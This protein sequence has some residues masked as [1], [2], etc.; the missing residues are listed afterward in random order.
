MRRLVTRGSAVLLVV[1]AV[2]AVGLPRAFSDPSDLTGVWSLDGKNG[3]GHYTG[4]VTLAKVGVAWVAELTLDYDSGTHGT[5][6]V[7]ATFDGTVLSGTRMRTTGITGALTG[8]KR[9]PY[10][11]KYTLSADGLTLDGTYA[12]SF[13]ERFT[14]KAAPVTGSATI[15]VDADR[16]GALTDK[17]RAAATA[18]KTALLTLVPG[19][20]GTVLSPIQVEVK[21]GT[22]TIE[23]APAGAL[24]ITEGSNAVGELALGTHSL[25][26]EAVTEG[27]VEVR[28]V[29]GGTVV[30]RAKITVEKEKLYLILG[31]YFSTEITYQEGD[32]TK[33]K[34]HILPPLQQA[35]YTVIEDGKGYDQSVID[36]RL[37]DPRLSKKVIVDWCTTDDDFNHYWDRQTVKAYFWESHGF[38]EPYPGC[39]D[40]ELKV[41]ESRQWTAAPGDPSNTGSRHFV[42]DWKAKLDKNGYATLDF[43]VNHACTTGGIGDYSSDPWEYTDADTLTR[44][45]A[46]LGDPLPTFDKLSYT[47]HAS[48]KGS[49]G[50]QQNYDGSAYFGVYDVTWA[51]LVAAIKP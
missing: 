4:S 7:D 13:T 24:K 8:A 10:P 17:D 49:F 51:S 6:R 3:T 41:L 20:P 32:L 21:T 37:T 22:A 11:A 30:D 43:G 2:S 28:V 44:A 9:T 5:A 50:F 26:A 31:A 29:S 18:G 47:T 1:L 40:A 27:D 39:P 15:L 23:L 46:V 34:S 45:K 14:R 42:R 48:L 38:M 19:A 25:M 12:T 16:D 36:K 35:G 33:A